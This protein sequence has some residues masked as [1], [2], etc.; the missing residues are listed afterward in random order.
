[1]KWLLVFLTALL[2]CG[3]SSCAPSRQMLQQA[4]S[5]LDTTIAQ[6]PG[7]GEFAIV[8]IL[9]GES[10]STDYGRTCYYAQAYIAVGTFLP[11]REALAAYVHEL[12]LQGWTVAQDEYEDAKVL[13]RGEHERLSIELGAPGWIVEREESYQRAREV[14][15]TILNIVVT[16]ILPGRE[17][18]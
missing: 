17:N 7:S 6:L 11:G 18:C 4:R 13:V 14:Y 12:S 8:T 3:I 15:P 2:L 10:A 9:R 5:G 1:M 16:Y